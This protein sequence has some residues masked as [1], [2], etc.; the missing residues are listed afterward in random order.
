MALRA[1]T[2]SYVNVYIYTSMA[3]S[4]HVVDSTTLIHNK[5][6]T[7]IIITLKMIGRT[8]FAE[9]LFQNLATKNIC[10]EITK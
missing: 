9:G 7:I 3:F 10:G 4:E 5:M 6:A 2:V 1:E 8:G